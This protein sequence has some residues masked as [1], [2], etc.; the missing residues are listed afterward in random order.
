MR[1]AWSFHC[2]RVR[3]DLWSVPLSL[4]HNALAFIAVLYTF[5]ILTH[6]VVQMILA[7][8]NFRLQNKQAR[9]LNAQVNEALDSDTF[10]SVSVI[11]PVYNESPAVLQSVL[12]HAAKCLAIPRLEILVIDDG[13]TNLDELEPVYDAYRG[14]RIRVAFV[15][16]GGK[17]TAQRVGFDMANGEYIVTVDSDTLITPDGVCNALAPMMLDPAIGAT[18][19][20]V[21]VANQNSNFLTHLIGIRYWLAFNVERA[22]QSFCKSMLCCS[23]PFSVYRSSVIDAVKKSYAE[24]LFFG[25]KCTY[26]DDRHLTNLVI[27][28]GYK[29]R[30]QQGALAYTYV[31]ETLPL[32]ISQQTRWN[33]SFYRELW[34][35]LKFASRVHD[36]ALWDMVLQPL[37]FLGFLFILGLDLSYAIRS[38]APSVL[39]FLLP[40]WTLMALSRGLYGLVRTGRSEF[41]LIVVYTLL[42]ITVLMPV[43]LKAM[44]TL[45]DNSWGTRAT[46]PRYAFGDFGLWFGLYVA[47]IAGAAIGISASGLRL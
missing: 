31:P 3:L 10:P 33:K 17:R 23:G 36:Y 39:L 26:G 6:L 35:T 21:R 16:N 41:L 32:Y 22:A 12:E 45:S 25:K 18:T 28:I 7:Q 15:S 37:L 47:L 4:P 44:V 2:S 40:I 1:G 9:I 29:T 14:D 20:E 19:G 38:S 5:V 8:L 11:Y 27:G 34:W 13:S 30:Y 43:R 42:H 46:G 24:Q